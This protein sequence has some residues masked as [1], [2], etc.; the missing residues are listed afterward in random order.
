[1]RD[2]GPLLLH[3]KNPHVNKLIP[4]GLQD[5]EGEMGVRGGVLK[6]NWGQSCREGLSEEVTFKLKCKGKKL[7]ATQA[8]GKKIPGRGRAGAKVL[9]QE[10]A[11]AQDSPPQ[12]C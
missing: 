1:M 8:S 5:L 9:R 6:K 4:G 2:R 12:L 10:C 11:S 3:S 7:S